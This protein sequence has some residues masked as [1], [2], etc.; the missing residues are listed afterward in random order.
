VGPDRDLR[1]V[2]ALT[3]IRPATLADLHR[4][5]RST[6][7]G[8]RCEFD[9]FDQV[10]DQVFG[11]LVDPAGGRGDP[12]AGDR[13]KPPPSP[14]P[15]PPATG[16]PPRAGEPAGGIPRSGPPAAGGADPGEPP[17]A[18]LPTL[19]SAT[20]R[21]AG[22]DFAEL[23]PADLALLGELMSR[24][25][26]ATPDRPSRRTRVVPA[27]ERLDLR[28]SLRLAH[29]TGGDPVRLL[30]RRRRRRA[31]RLVVLCDISGSMEP[32]ARAIVQFL[33]SAAGGAD[34]EVFTFA[35]RLT[36]LTRVVATPAAGSAIERAGRTA[37]DWS[38]GTRIGAALKEFNERYGRR[39]MARGAVVLIVSDG[40][41]TG[42]VAV[43]A[44]EMDRLSRVA[45]RIV[46]ANPR[47][48]SP[49][50]RPLASGMAAAWPFCDVVVSAHRLTE[51]DDLLAALAD[52]VRRR[53]V[54]L[55]S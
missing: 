48:Q 9:V 8:D 32:Y 27:G 35:T 51:L 20:E 46:W 3:L 15:A 12:N 47:T 53:R 26:I 25:A 21:L 23:T 43:L 13:G 14:S 5:G 4:C 30:R 16:S 54:H 10:F 50:F 11:G 19:A 7:T 37:P 18:S 17:E 42:D 31:R 29:R 33:Y 49:R 34:A 28:G 36:R 45:Y 52:P 1:F 44:K 39:G 2:R 41:E 40:W 55:G 38:G 24:L 22:R 6:L